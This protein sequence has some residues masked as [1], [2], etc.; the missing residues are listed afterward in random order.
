MRR[1]W[2]SVVVAAVAVLGMVAP[3]GASSD[4]VHP[5]PAPPVVHPR[6]TPPVGHPRPTP[7]GP[8]PHPTPPTPPKPTP[9]IPPGH[10]LHL[11][12][13]DSLA[14]G[15]Q[16]VPP[17]E[18]YAQTMELWKANGFVALFHAA[19][20]E[21]L[22]CSPGHGPRP[23]AAHGPHGCRHLGLV[24]LARPGIPGVAGGV[25][26]AT[27]LEPGDQLDQAVA[28]LEARN[29]NRSP[30]DD[31]R[32]VTVSV[33]GND[34]T[35]TAVAACVQTTAQ[36]APTLEATFA[37]FAE[38]YDRILATLREGA[39]P[40][41]EIVTMTLYNPLPYC[42]AGQAVGSEW[43]QHAGDVVL[44]G[45]DLVPGVTVAQGYND[46]LRDVAARYDVTVVETFGLLDADDLVGGADCTHP[47]GD[48][49][50]T[51]A[52]LFAAAVG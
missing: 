43:V 47:D 32:V 15:Q 51:L 26:T 28:L 30:H 52:D 27:V 23:S 25:T 46:V 24:N 34:V 5:R 48:G 20:R 10:P 6:P 45:G 37:G 39:G 36:C 49:H 2:T 29:G 7:P 35:G 42:A 14:A 8:V 22:D 3:A 38:R 9:P 1:A 17:V 21:R 44:E 12:L 40:D 33:G 41:A 50:R 31:V 11:A 19:L 18:D 16:S 13:G 4:V